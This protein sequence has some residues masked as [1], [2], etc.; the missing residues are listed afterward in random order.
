MQF[1]IEEAEICALL[2]IA[3]FVC[4]S[5]AE[6]GIIGVPELRLGR[7]AMGHLG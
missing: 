2:D 3:Q 5:T 7:G 4:D 1:E 6:S